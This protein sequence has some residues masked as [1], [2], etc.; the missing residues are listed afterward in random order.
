MFLVLLGRFVKN[1]PLAHDG[2]GGG[3]QTVI[4]DLFGCTV[5][6][7]IVSRLSA[8]VGNEESRVD[9]DD[10]VKDNDQQFHREVE[11]VEA[12]LGVIPCRIVPGSRSR[13]I[14]PH[15]ERG[16]QSEERCGQHQDE[17]F[18][19]KAPAAKLFHPGVAWYDQAADDEWNGKKSNDGVES[20]TV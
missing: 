10:N 14:D 13:V 20:L 18:G 17:D 11:Y 9:P 12:R 2:V 1:R 6:A 16:P 15:A 3:S 19:T 5:P 8:P 4:A 7:R